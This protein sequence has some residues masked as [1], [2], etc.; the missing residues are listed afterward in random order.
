MLPAGIFGADQ[1]LRTLLIYTGNK[2]RN[3][4]RSRLWKVKKSGS[5][6]GK[7]SAYHQRIIVLHTFTKPQRQIANRLG[8]ALHTNGLVVGERVHLACDS[9]VLNHC[10]GVGC[11]T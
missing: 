5:E 3:T 11:E 7:N 1:Q 2:K 10:S 4:K 6:Y 8:T 9:S